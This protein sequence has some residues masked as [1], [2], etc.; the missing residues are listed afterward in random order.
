MSIDLGFL[1]RNRCFSLKWLLSYQHE[2]E[3][4]LLQTHYFSENLVASEFKSMTSESVARNSLLLD[5]RG[6]Q[7][8]FSSGS[9]R[10]RTISGQADKRVTIYFAV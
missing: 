5:H 8:D 6:S 10:F 3:W 1:D 2:A 9:V 7:I 4:T